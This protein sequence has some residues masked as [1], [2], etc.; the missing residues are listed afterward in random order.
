M[1][2]VT[3]GELVVHT[4]KKAGVEMLFGLHGAH[5]DTIF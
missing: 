4:L 5:I 3:G 1:V 2:M